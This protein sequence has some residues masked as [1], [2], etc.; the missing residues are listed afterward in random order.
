[1]AKTELTDNESLDLDDIRV[2][3]S[4]S[5]LELRSGKSTPAAI[6]AISNATGKILSSVKLEMEYHKQTGQRPHI[7]MMA[8]LGAPSDGAQPPD[9]KTRR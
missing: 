4:E 2:I 9:E 3:L 8:Q 1:M 5:I 6:N 7:K